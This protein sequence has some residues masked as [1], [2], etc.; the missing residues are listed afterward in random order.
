M[1][2]GNVRHVLGTLA[3]GSARPCDVAPLRWGYLMRR[4][5]D[6]VKRRIVEHL[7][8]YRSHAEVV[9]LIAA[10]FDI[11]LTP[12]HV[13][14]YDP[15]CFQ[16]AGGTRWQEY[17]GLVRHRL[18]TELA[19]IPI[20]HRAFR[21]R[22]L[23][24]L[25][26]MARNAG[27]LEEARKALEQAAKETGNVYTNVAKVQ[28]SILPGQPADDRTPEEARNMLA[29]RLREA[30]ERLPKAKKPTER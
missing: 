28:G 27:D 7:A 29:E 13:R 25:H 6:P 14:A 20:A 17:H 3:T 12:R 26:D 23:G 24:Q 30:M 8:C 11:A 16:F 10:E 22:R 4:L 21:L 19:E 5:P 1:P 15:M 2:D 9:E 18:E